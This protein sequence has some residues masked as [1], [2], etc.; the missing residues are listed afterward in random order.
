MKNKPLV[1]IITTSY[2]LGRFIEDAIL[3]IKNQ[4]YPNIE[5]IIVD[6]GSTDN[7]LEILRKY[8]GTYNMRW[9]SESDEGQS[10][11]ANK[12]F[13]MAKGEI[14]GWLDSD[15]VYFTKD[16]ISYVVNEFNRNPDVDV[17][18]GNAVFI[19]ENNTILRVQRVSNWNYNRLLRGFCISQPATFFRKRVVLENQLDVNLEYSNDFEFLLRLGRKYKFLHVNKIL[20]GTRLRK[21]RKRYSNIT[22]A[23]NEDKKIMAMYGQDFGLSYYFLRYFYDFPYLMLKRLFGIIDILEIE[24][25]DLAFKAKIKGKLSRIRSQL[26]PVYLYKD[27]MKKP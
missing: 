5:H 26:F 16:V 12:G 21:Q 23:K 17:I 3:S 14:I 10:D 7:T 25:Q 1:S 27:I 4:D 2:N 15:D 11:A 6:G 22:L 8:E 19:D 20:A 24:K 9:I 18:Y 13:R